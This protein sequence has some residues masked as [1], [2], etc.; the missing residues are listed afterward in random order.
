MDNYPAPNLNRK[1][2]NLVKAIVLEVGI[3]SL[4]T[5]VLILVLNYFQI[6]DFGLFTSRDENKKSVVGNSPEAITPTAISKN[7]NAANFTKQI[8]GALVSGKII[9]QY[10]GK[11]SLIDFKEGVDKDQGNFKYKVKMNIIGRGVKESTILFDHKALSTLKV[12]ETKESKNVGLQI[13]DLKVNDK[14]KVVVTR[15]LNLNLATYEYSEIEIT[16]LSE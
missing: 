14:V 3:I 5:I 2:N 13:G 1:R 10:E 16:R 6:I 4:L 12:I 15:S 8:N 11:I 9:N 7:T